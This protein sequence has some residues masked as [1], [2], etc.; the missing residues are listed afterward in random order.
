MITRSLLLTTEGIRRFYCTAWTPDGPAWCARPRHDGSPDTLP[1]PP[2]L[3]RQISD[4][5]G[6]RQSVCGLV[7]G[8]TR[9][10]SAVR[11]FVCWWCVLQQT[12]TATKIIPILT[13]FSWKNCEIRLFFALSCLSAV[14]SKYCST[15]LLF[16]SWGPAVGGKTSSSTAVLVI[17]G[18]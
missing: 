16:G 13:L 3:L 9:R 1:R 4:T 8:L 10:R 15:L 12:T 18:N 17:V 6:Q 7:L 5:W 11:V 2:P 14:Q